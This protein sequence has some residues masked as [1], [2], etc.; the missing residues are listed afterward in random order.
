MGNVCHI[1]SQSLELET[2]RAKQVSSTDTVLPTNMS[3]TQNVVSHLRWDNFDINEE[4]PSGPGT[5]YT[6]RGIVVQEVKSSSTELVT[7]AVRLLPNQRSE[8]SIL[9]LQVYQRAT[10][11]SESCRHCRYRILVEK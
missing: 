3:T 2:A 1:Y 6:T 8:V 4:T 11:R 10:V 5:I 9:F 7:G